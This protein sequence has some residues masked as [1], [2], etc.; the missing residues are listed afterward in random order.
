MVFGGRTDVQE[1]HGMGLH[2]ARRLAEA[3]QGRLTL[4][5][6]ASPVF[7]LLLPRAEDVLPEETEMGLATAPRE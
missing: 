5:R 4:Y 2:L 3:E 7:T 6:T 1:G